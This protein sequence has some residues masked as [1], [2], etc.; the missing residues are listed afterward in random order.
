MK[1]DS[2]KQGKFNIVQFLLTIF[3]IYWKSLGTYFQCPGIPSNI[4]L[5]A[6][7]DAIYFGIN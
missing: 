5:F 3:C 1:C 7:Y 4:L 6:G 2:V